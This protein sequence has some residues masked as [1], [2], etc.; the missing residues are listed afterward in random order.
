[1]I[2][3]VL[4]K[5]ALAR[6]VEITQTNGYCFFAYAG[7]SYLIR[8]VWITTISRKKIMIAPS[9]Q[10][11]ADLDVLKELIEAA[12]LKSVIDRR[13]P[14]EYMSAA[15]QYAESGR[16]KGTVVIQ[17]KPNNESSGQQH[18]G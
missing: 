17:V 8:R 18:L 12:K 16:K 6:Q 4:G 15:H 13:F 7:L 3:D 9:N 5:R 10:S 2:I 1:M 14:L 11:R